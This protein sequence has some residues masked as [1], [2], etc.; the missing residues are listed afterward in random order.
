MALTP[1][2]LHLAPILKDKKWR[3]QHRPH[4]H[5][6][7]NN[8]ED[9]A[10]ARG[11]KLSQE[12]KSI[13][14]RIDHHFYLVHLR[15]NEIF[16]SAKLAKVLKSPAYKVKSINFATPEELKHYFGLIKGQ[17]NPFDKVFQ[18]YRQIFS[19]TLFLGNPNLYTNDCTL[20]GYISF[21]PKLLFLT[22]N[23]IV[24][25][26]VKEGAKLPDSR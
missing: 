20:D 10:V 11:I 16:S 9:A 8:C 21:S 23:F 18:H 24:A 12:L 19:H 13:V 2:L 25:D 7:I 1:N 4:A 17:V 5:N 22:K 26:I 14:L 3:F 6:P 15:G